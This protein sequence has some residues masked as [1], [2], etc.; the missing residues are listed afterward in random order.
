MSK[1]KLQEDLVQL[2]SAVNDADLK[3]PVQIQLAELI[4][5]MESQL[6]E[7]ATEQLAEL[8]QQY[9]QRWQEAIADFELEHPS[10]TAM[11]NNILVSLSNMGV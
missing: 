2:K 3:Q 1:Q 6:N 10:L 5:D 7:S 9:K 11:V 8:G 4:A